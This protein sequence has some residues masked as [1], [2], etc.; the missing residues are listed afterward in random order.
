M[1]SENENTTC[2]NLWATA[3]FVLIETFI[4]LSAHIF[5]KKG[6][7]SERFNGAYWEL[8]T[9]RTNQTLNQKVRHNKIRTEIK[10]IETKQYERSTQQIVGFLRL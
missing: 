3:K 1:S 7:I 9:V 4:T 10:E 8:R 5:F 2:Q 6:K